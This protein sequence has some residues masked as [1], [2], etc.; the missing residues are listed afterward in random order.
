[1]GCLMSSGD[2]SIISLHHVMDA[3]ASQFGVDTCPSLLVLQAWRQYAKCATN[4]LRAA[5]LPKNVKNM[6]GDVP[7]NPRQM[8]QSLAGMSKV[9]LT[10]V[11]W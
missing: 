6:K 4:A 5:H 7:M 10:V 11:P 3:W 1:M 2:I 8:Q 9:R